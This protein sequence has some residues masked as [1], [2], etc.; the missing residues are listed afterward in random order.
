MWQLASGAMYSGVPHALNAFFLSPSA[1]LQLQPKSASV[2][3]SAAPCSRIL[4][5][6]AVEEGAHFS[7]MPTRCVCCPLQ[8]GEKRLSLCWGL[9]ESSCGKLPQTVAAAATAAR[10]RE[11]A[12]A[13]K[14][15]PSTH[16][17]P[18]YE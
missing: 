3:T 14:V 16:A 13:E 4:S 1:S 7:G 8:C 10:L 17:L 9:A 12:G 15:H 6:C 2:T 5:S 11:R 18:H